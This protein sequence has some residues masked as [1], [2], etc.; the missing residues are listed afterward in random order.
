[1]PKVDVKTPPVIKRWIGMKCRSGIKLLGQEAG[2][3]HSETV[4]AF[5][6]DVTSSKA[7]TV[8]LSL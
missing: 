3:P 1:M 6:I 7:L 4:F 5:V 2:A 8:G